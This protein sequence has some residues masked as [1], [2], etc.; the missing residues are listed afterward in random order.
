MDPQTQL[1][2][3]FAAFMEWRTKAAGTTPG[4]YPAHGPGGVF[5]Q[6]GQRA[7]VV[8][9]MVM[10]RG[11][12]D[13][14]P[15][16]RSNYFREVYPILTGLTAGTG[17]NPET[18][19]ADCRQ[20]GNLKVCNQTW[21]F[22]R[23]CL[24]SQVIDVSSLGMLVNRSEFVDQVLVGDPFGSLGAS[25]PAA[26]PFNPREA[27]R[28]EKSK[29]LMQLFTEWKRSWGRMI[30]TGNPANNSGTGYAEHYGLDVIVNT[31]Y[32]DAYTGVVCPAADAKVISFGNLEITTNGPAA[33]T[34]IIEMYAA[35]K[36]LSKQVGLDPVKW[37]LV[38]R[39][40]LF[41]KLTEIWPC[42]YYTANCALPTGAT[43]G[44]TGT[45]ISK[46]R[47]D[48]RQGEYLIID[49]EHV[50]FLV[51][52]FITETIP[53]SGTAQSDL[54]FL[55]LS[56]PSF[57]HNPGGAITYFEFFDM[58][59]SVDIATSGVGAYPANTF[60]VL[61]GGRYLLYPKAPSN[62]CIQYG[63]ISKD[64]LIVEA[65]FL[66]AR[67]TGMRYTFQHHERSY[68]PAAAYYFYNGG[69]YTFAAPY[70]YPPTS[71]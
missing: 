45:E 39:Y 46:L 44:L 58:A 17:T 67:I 16:K 28:N 11:L 36:H 26:L 24:D 50:E 18:A 31:G 54:Y 29:Q 60:Q 21:P 53:V 6:P 27:L 30:Y 43:L 35:L 49:G 62:V 33:V 12:R 4:T 13:R 22:S 3:E 57:S 20:P 19:C 68:D 52:D 59:N 66:S 37:V 15:A 41:R 23:L 48:M 51:D 14:L 9:A 42:T 69:Q 63:M 1:A 38:G 8:N 34:A 2:Q 25:A 47:D 55:P 56:S 32:R 10:P 71:S 61:G 64:R 40:G 65:P 7:Q 5:A 70:F